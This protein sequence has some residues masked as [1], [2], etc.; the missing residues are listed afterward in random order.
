MPLFTRW[1]GNN[2]CK[3]RGIR[4]GKEIDVEDLEYLWDSY[5]KKRGRMRP[6]KARQFLK[7]LAKEVDVT[8]SASLVEEL[9]RDSN[10]SSKGALTKEEFLG[11]FF[12]Y[13]TADRLELPL[14]ERLASDP[15]A[16]A[17]TPEL[18]RR[19]EEAEEAWAEQLVMVVEEEDQDVEE[20][21]PLEE[22]DPLDDALLC[23]DDYLGEHPDLGDMDFGDSDDQELV[24]ADMGQCDDGYEIAFDEGHC[25]LGEASVDEMGSGA[26]AVVLRE[27]DVFE[28]MKSEAAKTGEIYAL[29]PEESLQVLSR[30]EWVSGR[31]TE[32]QDIESLRRECGIA[33]E[34]GCSNGG[35]TLE[36]EGDEFECLVCMEDMLPGEEVFALA[37][38]H[39]VCLDCWH[40]NISVRLADY[41][42]SYI[43]CP[44]T[45]CK[46]ALLDSHVRLLGTEKQYARYRSL[47]VENY[48]SVKK[49]LIFC[50]S[51]RC[52]EILK[53]RNLCTND[54]QVRCSCGSVFC[55]HCAKNR[56]TERGEGHYP[57]TC[58][59][60]KQW[61]QRTE[62]GVFSFRKK[63][64]PKCK[65][66]IIKC[67]CPPNHVICEEKEYCPNQ[68]CN[69]MNCPQCNYH[70]CWICLK[71]WAG[72]NDYYT[73]K[74]VLPDQVKNRE[75]ISGYAEIYLKYKNY[76]GSYRAL[77]DGRPWAIE[78][79]EN[80]KG[81][82]GSWSNNFLLEAVEELAMCY[83][84][85][86]NSYILYF[87]NDFDSSNSM[88]PGMCKSLFEFNQQ[89]LENVT[90][91]LSNKYEK[92][93]K[94]KVKEG[95]EL[96]PELTDELMSLTRVIRDYRKKLFANEL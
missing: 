74:F 19:K 54:Y 58:D 52:N 86:A 38:G 50:N 72:H 96:P 9:I 79:F 12:K 68:A 23:S 84:T 78:H 85:L 6:N 29:T 75:Y 33:A 31:L 37:C 14:S 91:Q 70:F 61:L 81:E 69:H 76:Y 51:P 59:H 88:V 17:H 65:T 87:Y 30:L 40:Q 7:H 64:C 25:C 44:A 46:F 10:P 47:F 93:V 43:E 3:R 5:S 34:V 56:I 2:Y 36:G 28:Q 66:P 92:E 60:F 90:N 21:N 8:F 49:N 77:L 45:D 89:N 94:R 48:I 11:L 1:Q 73:C 42:P 4:P 18:R 71:P 82:G 16:I 80:L 67:G 15:H 22:S 95:A 57:A 39:T 26:G 55:F 35:C 83:H 63:P 41:R 62:D 27:E 24:F 53:I 32:V 13:R 20:E